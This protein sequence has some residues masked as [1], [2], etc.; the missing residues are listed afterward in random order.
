M[1]KSKTEDGMV[2]SAL[3]SAAMMPEGYLSPEE[4][5]HR[6]LLRM[7]GHVKDAIA[8]RLDDATRCVRI[9]MRGRDRR[10]GAAINFR[11]WESRY[12]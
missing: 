1:S 11:D 7:L 9:E 10:G 2:E 3:E 5:R 12:D 6:K 8:S 4:E